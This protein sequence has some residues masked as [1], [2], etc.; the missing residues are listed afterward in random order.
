MHNTT[1]NKEKIT[2][3]IEKKKND[4]E[5]QL[6]TLLY[7]NTAKPDKASTKVESSEEKTNLL[8][9]IRSGPSLSFVQTE[10]YLS[11]LLSFPPK[12]KNATHL[13]SIYIPISTF[14]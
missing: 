7:T 14:L 6:Q 3:K 1:L 12:T 8:I 10:N 2:N 5:V 4:T 11:S 9:Q 13:L